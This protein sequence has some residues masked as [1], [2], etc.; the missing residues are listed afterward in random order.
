MIE[1]YLA[2]QIETTQKTYE[3]VWRMIEACMAQIVHNLP[4]STTLNTTT[5]SEPHP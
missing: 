3:P 2:Q 1:A 5:R 4:L